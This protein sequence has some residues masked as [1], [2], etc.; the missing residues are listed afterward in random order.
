[1]EIMKKPLRSLL[2]LLALLSIASAAQAQANLVHGIGAAVNLGRMAG[3]G[4]LGGKDKTVTTDTYRD[5][6]FPMKRTPAAQLTGDAA[7]QIGL[8]EAQLE[9]CHRA[10]EKPTAVICPPNQLAV[11]NAAQA[12]IARARPGWNQKFYKQ[13]LAFYLAEDA[14]RQAAA[15]PAAPA[16]TPPAPETAPK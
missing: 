12:V 16:P 3:R 14:R 6:E 8:L 7:D 15:A 9:Q 11:I 4:G 2:A 1:M 13:E 5:Q 10:L